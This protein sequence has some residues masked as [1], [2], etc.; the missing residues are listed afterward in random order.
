L[1]LYG[2]DIDTATS[3]IEAG[4]TWAV[5]KRR[6]ETADFPGA[7]SILEQ[8]KDGPLRKRVG[9]LPDGRAPVRE[10]AVIRDAG[11]VE[12]G[13]VTS[14]GFGPSVGGPVAMGYVST[15]SATV[16]TA[17]NIELRGRTV[18][19]TLVDLP[20]VPANYKRAS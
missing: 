8:L 6:R 13:I 12:I 20:F 9:L 5:G 3:P 19:A 2:H 17:L 18:A 7:G 16:G 1:C 11:D 14:G 4:L 10:G 15:A